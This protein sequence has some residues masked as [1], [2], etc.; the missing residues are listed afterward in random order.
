MTTA[1]I[2]GLLLCCAGVTT[3]RAAWRRPQIR[4]RWAAG[5]GWLLLALSLYS[6]ALAW[7]WEFGS[8][9]LLAAISLVAVVVLLANSE[10]RPP[11]VERTAGG[12]EGSSSA[13]HKWSLFLVAGP[14]AGIASCQLTLLLVLLLPGGEIGS[15]AAAAVLFPVAWALLAFYT[16]YLDKPARLGTGLLLAALMSSLALY[17]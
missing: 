7:G 17:L 16:C 13:L 1:A 15:M 12:M 8:S 9:Y 2:G 4:W 3:L 11:G 5:A 14:L 6:G 10:R